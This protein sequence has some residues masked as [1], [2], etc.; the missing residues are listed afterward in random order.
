YRDAVAA[1]PAIPGK[2]LPVNDG[3]WAPAVLPEN[4]P[5]HYRVCENELGGLVVESIVIAP[6]PTGPS[7]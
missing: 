3:I 6:N 4:G 1:V 5:Y 2:S 7:R